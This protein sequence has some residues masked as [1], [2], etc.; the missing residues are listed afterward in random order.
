MGL[1]AK[2]AP[3]P[4]DSTETRARTGSKPRC[5]AGMASREFRLLGP[6][7]DKPTLQPSFNTKGAA[8]IRPNR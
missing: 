7:D 8:F 4:Y 6:P 3:S 5:N 2:G 1:E